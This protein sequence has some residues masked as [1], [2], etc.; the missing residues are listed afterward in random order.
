MRRA[1]DDT[2]G[3]PAKSILHFLSHRLTLFV[4]YTAP[5]ILRDFLRYTQSFAIVTVTS[6]FYLGWKS[7][8]SIMRSFIPPLPAFDTSLPDPFIA[9]ISHRPLQSF[10]RVSTSRNAEPTRTSLNF[11]PRDFGPA[12]KIGSF[13]IL[14]PN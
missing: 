12:H 10:L 5:M 9:D 1:L 6:L 13:R 3:P 14:V 11:L 7:F 8:F 2:N 4:E